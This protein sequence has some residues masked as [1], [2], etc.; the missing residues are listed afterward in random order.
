MARDYIAGWYGFSRV[1]A[2]IL[3]TVYGGLQHLFIINCD[4]A[5]SVKGDQSHGMYK[6]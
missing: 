3:V 1:A 6:I 2:Y 4:T 5:T